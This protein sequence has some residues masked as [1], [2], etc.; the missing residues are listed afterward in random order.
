MKCIKT[1]IVEDDDF[2]I[3]TTK[4]YLQRFEKETKS[5]HF[6][7]ESFLSPIDFLDKYKGDGELLFL[8]IRMPGINGM[9]T[10]KE[11]RKKDPL[12]TIIF[13]T[14][15]GQYAIEGY[16]VEAFDFLLKPLKYPEFKIKLFRI[17]NNVISKDSDYLMINVSNSIIKLPFSHILYVETQLHNVLIHDNDLNVYKKHI[18]MKEIEDSL[19]K[20]IFCRINSSF[21]VNFDYCLGI[22]KD[23][24]ILNDRTRL[25][26]S[27]P[28]MKQVMDSFKMFR[29]E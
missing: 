6:Q 20:E 8:D 28:R 26:I 3:E 16:S 23:E 15:L 5:C 4:E 27:R 18:S 19:P 21:I 25:K 13:I 14:S 22:E 11:I 24:M 12:I 29:K 1:Y 10:A 17:V 9:E 7:V 2:Q